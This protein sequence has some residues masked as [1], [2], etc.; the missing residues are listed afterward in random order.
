MSAQS[1]VRQQL[2]FWHGAL[3]PIMSDCGPEALHKSLPGATITSIASIYAHLVFAEDVI[4]NA[5]LL[6]KPPIYQTDGW[7]AKTGVP[8]AGMPPSITPEWAQGLQMNL[9][10]FQEYEKEVSGAV[11]AYLAGLSDADLARKVSGPFGEQTVEWVIVNLLGTHAPQH[12]GEIAALK[13]VQ[14]M[15]GLPF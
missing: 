12:A 1:A 9:P 2:A 13:G 3:G 7:E 8:F 14:G 15:K 6:G 10:A 5:M 11:D 4:T